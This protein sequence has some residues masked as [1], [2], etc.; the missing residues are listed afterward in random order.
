MLQEAE[1]TFLFAFVADDGAD[2]GDDG[3]VAMDGCLELDVLQGAEDE[4]REGAGEGDGV[5]EGRGVEGV[6]TRARGDAA[7][8]SDQAGGL[9]G[10]QVFLGDDALDV[11][12]DGGG[13]V[14][15]G[16]AAEGV[17]VLMGSDVVVERLEE[18]DFEELVGEDELER[19]YCVGGEGD[20]GGDGREETAG[21]ALDGGVEGQGGG[22]GGEERGEAEEGRDG[23]RLHDGT[24]GFVRLVLDDCEVFDLN[25]GGGW[26]WRYWKRVEV[27]EESGGFQLRVFVKGVGY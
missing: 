25:G 15:E 14:V 13:G 21:G 27:L 5:I 26:E 1:E 16:G 19:G 6:G 20:G 23:D 12:G 3:E 2:G 4:V 18:G 22:Y 8:C 17:A 7:C 24:G 11:C 9:G 10:V